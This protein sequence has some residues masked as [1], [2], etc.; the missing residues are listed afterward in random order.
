MSAPTTFGALAPGARFRL[1]PAGEV[2]R[3]VNGLGRDYAGPMP[4][5]RMTGYSL[6][7]D[8]KVYP[9]SDAEYLEHLRGEIRAERISWGELADLQ[10][11]AELIDPGD[12][13]LL[14]WAGVPE[15]PEERA[16]FFAERARERDGLVDVRVP[17]VLLFR[18]PPTLHPGE[19]AGFVERVFEHGTIRDVFEAAIDGAGR[20]SLTYDG[21]I[22]PETE[23]TPA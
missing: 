18:A 4:D 20:D 19:L 17:V 9:L 23:E 6:A 13:E 2:W 22:V 11:M 15:H 3:K 14:E 5:P 12:V 1:L 21:Y 8:R 16:A 7:D 10:D